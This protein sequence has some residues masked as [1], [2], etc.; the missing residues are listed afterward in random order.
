MSTILF[1]NDLNYNNKW[2]ITYQYDYLFWELSVTQDGKFI[3]LSILNN[4]DDKYMFY[5]PWVGYAAI[6]RI[7]TSDGSINLSKALSIDRQW[8]SAV[9]FSASQ[10][11]YVHWWSSNSM[12]LVKLSSTDFSVSDS[13][14]Y[15][16]PSNCS[17]LKTF[18]DKIKLSDSS[19]ELLVTLGNDSTS[20]I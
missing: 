8:N 7:L 18:L 4:L 17:N 6:I 2:T 19:S 14:K 12:F 1:K 3:L 10:F 9:S 13:Y 5:L 11:T 15:T 20:P 16:F